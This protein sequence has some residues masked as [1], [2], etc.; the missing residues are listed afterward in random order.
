MHDWRCQGWC[1]IWLHVD[2]EVSGWK[3]ICYSRQWRLVED[4]CRLETLDGQWL[5]GLEASTLQWRQWLKMPAG[6]RCSLLSTVSDRFGCIDL[7]RRSLGIGGREKLIF[8]PSSRL[9]SAWSR[10]SSIRCCRPFL[11]KCFLQPRLLFIV[12]QI[13]SVL[14]DL[15]Y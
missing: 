12:R 3:T 7:G 6:W 14:S 8:V 11:V 9:M 5:T 10:V 1:W 15:L 13:C 2:S 4:D